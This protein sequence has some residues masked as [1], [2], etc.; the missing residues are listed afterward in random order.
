VKLL[1]KGPRTAGPPSGVVAQTTPWK[2]DD[3]ARLA[4]FEIPS[5]IAIVACY[6]GAKHTET[7]DN[8]LYWVV[9]AI[10]AMLL[11]GAGWTGWLLVGSRALR[12]RQRQLAEVTVR[13]GLRKSPQASFEVTVTGPKMTH[14]HRPDCPLAR[15]RKVTT[16][17][18]EEQLARGLTPCGVCLG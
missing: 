16:A 5:L 10:A 1:T 11:A 9:G 18:A 13:F 15:G 12:R 8:Q 14:F 6:I 7:W 3:F 17:T 2:V 4:R